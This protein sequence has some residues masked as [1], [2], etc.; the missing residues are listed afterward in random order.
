MPTAAPDNKNVGHVA[1]SSEQEN[2]ILVLRS[3]LL[4]GFSNTVPILIVHHW[5]RVKMTNISKE[6]LVFSSKEKK[7]SVPQVV[8]I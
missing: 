5:R 8:V 6:N 3:E 4:A 7:I 2:T 1:P